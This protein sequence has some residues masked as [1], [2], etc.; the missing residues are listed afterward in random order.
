MIRSSSVLRRTVP[1]V[2]ALLAAAVLTACGGAAHPGAA[3][4]VG[5]NRITISAVQSRIAEIRAEAA[6]QPGVASQESS[7]LAQSTV[8]Q[9][10]M[11]EVVD[12]AVASH[13]LTVSD[14]EIAQVRQDQATAWGGEAALDQMLLV[15]RGVP[16]GQI[17][18]F[19]RELIGI[20][21]LAG[22]SGQQVGTTEGNKAVHQLLS[23][24]SAELKV[25]VNPRYGSWDAQQAIV[26]GPWD[27][28]L[29]QPGTA[30]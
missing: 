14:T 5:D 23:Q 13:G 25:S 22:L 11:T 4:V 16:T 29:P 6:A 26:T 9:M 10:V 20:N 19:Y 28:W 17:D 12:H 30:T 7:D 27:A 8:S 15:K 24:A 3:A 18:T 2:G 1:A 21:K